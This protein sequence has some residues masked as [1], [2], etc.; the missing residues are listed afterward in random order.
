MR[1]RTITERNIAIQERAT[2]GEPIDKLALEYGLARGTVYMI[3]NKR[4]PK[5]MQRPG[6]VDPFAKLER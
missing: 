1:P 6:D 3:T 5:K 2:R 4:K